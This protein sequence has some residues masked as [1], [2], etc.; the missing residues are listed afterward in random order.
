MFMNFEDINI[1]TKLK[2]RSLELTN[3]HFQI[4]NLER[5]FVLGTTISCNNRLIYNV[6]RH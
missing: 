5:K 4:Q 3:D 1:N 2:I 6:L